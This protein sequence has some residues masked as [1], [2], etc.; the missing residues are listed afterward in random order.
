MSARTEDANA[1]QLSEINA[2][3]IR[4]IA[5]L[6]VSESQGDYVASNALSVAEAYFEKGA[7]FRAITCLDMPVGFVM[8]FD[9]TL[10]GAIRKNGVNEN[11]IGLW[12]LMIDGRFQGRGFGKRALDLVSAHARTRPG[13]DAIISSFIPGPD[14]PEGFYKRYGFILTGNRRANGSEIEILLKL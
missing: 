9:H 10:P 6:R 13:I 12:R 8:L 11:E 5:A 2:S 14:G 3:T 7:W 4:A 1:I